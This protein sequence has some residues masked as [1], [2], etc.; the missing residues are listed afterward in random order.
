MTTHQLQLGGQ[1]L[2][3][4]GKG[5]AGALEFVL[6]GF[7]LRQLF[8]LGRFFGAEGLAPAEVFQGLLGVQYGL[9]QLLGLGLAR[10]TVGGHGLL[11]L[12]LL[13]LAL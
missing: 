11:G 8:Q 4:L 6:G 7:Q 3:A 10:G 13:Q 9:V 12:E 5:V 2:D 1:L